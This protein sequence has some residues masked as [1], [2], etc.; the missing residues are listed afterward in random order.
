MWL[1]VI[2]ILSLAAYIGRH[3]SNQRPVGCD[4]AWGEGV[5]VYVCLL[6]QGRRV[7]P[8]RY[9]C[10]YTDARCATHLYNNRISHM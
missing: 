4:I 9:M 8:P 1:K 3:Q 6:T 2:P 7:E 5:Y 10:V